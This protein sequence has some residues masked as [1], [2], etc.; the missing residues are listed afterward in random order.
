[1][2]PPEIL[3]PNRPCAGRGGDQPR[4]CGAARRTRSNAA[5]LRRTAAVVRG[6]GD[7]LDRADLEAGGLEGA[8]RGLTAGAGT[9]DEHVHLAHAVLLRAAGGRLGGHLRGEGGRLAR[10][11]E[12]DVAGGGPGD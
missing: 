1:A 12:A 10:A 7:V 4:C 8:D 9:L 6:G 3:S 11:L 2:V 5:A